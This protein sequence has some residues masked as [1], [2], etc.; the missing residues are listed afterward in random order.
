LENLDDDDDDDD[1]D[2]QRASESIRENTKA[3]A[4]DSPGYYELKQHKP[5]FHDECSEL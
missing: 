3:S 2:I 1:D 5:L 4:T